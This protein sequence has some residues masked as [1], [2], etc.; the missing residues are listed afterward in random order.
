[1]INYYTHIIILPTTLK[2]ALLLAG[3]VHILISVCV[4]VCVCVCL[5]KAEAWFQNQDILASVGML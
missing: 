2:Q 5:S 4:C 1:M 3:P